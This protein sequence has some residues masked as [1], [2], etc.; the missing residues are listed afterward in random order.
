VGNLCG[1]NTYQY[2]NDDGAEYELSE[3]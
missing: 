3:R 2:Y 1:A